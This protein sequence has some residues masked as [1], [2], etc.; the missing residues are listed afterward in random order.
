MN[1]C[2]IEDHEGHVL[3]QNKVNDSYTG[4]TFPGGHVEKEEIFKD[5]MIREVKEE[6]GLT[7]KNPYLCG[8]Y[9]WYKHSI[10][11]IILVYKASEYEGTLHSS[12]EGEV[13]WIDEEDFLKQPLATGMEYVWDIVHKQHQECIMSN[14]GEHKRGDLF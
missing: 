11:N 6:T 10:H 13:Y 1:M 3:I 8:L 4:I 14:M 7:I 9:H 5:A 12:D 2:M